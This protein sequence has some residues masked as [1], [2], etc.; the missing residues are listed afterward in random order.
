M[1]QEGG[2]TGVEDARQPMQRANLREPKRPEKPPKKHLVEPQTDVKD[3]EG[4]SR[5]RGVGEVTG[6]QQ[7]KCLQRCSKTPGEPEKENG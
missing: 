4:G 3:N 6:G 7:Y 5:T 2:A 1:E